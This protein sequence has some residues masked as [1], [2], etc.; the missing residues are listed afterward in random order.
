MCERNEIWQVKCKEL[1]M[2]FSDYQ[3]STSAIQKVSVHLYMTE[4]ISVGKSTYVILVLVLSDLHYADCF[5]SGQVNYKK[6]LKDYLSTLDNWDSGKF[7]EVELKGH[8]QNVLCVCLE[9]KKLHSRLASGK[10]VIPAI[11]A[12]SAVYMS[13]ILL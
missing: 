8:T 13:L 3:P 10:N 5:T 2:N 11:A 4:Y 6:L 7:K 1:N 9:A 12:T